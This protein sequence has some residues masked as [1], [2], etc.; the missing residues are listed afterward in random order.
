MRLILIRHGRPEWRL[1]R[2]ASLSQYR[3]GTLAYDAAGLSE[4]GIRKIRALESRLPEAVVWSSDLPRAKETAEIIAR[5]K[6]VDKVSPV[7]RELQAPT[8]GARFPGRLR[9]P[10][11]VW[12]LIHWGCWVAGIGEC[13][14]WPRAAWRRAGEAARLIRGSSVGEKTVILVSHGW[15]ITLLSAYLRKHGL[16]VHGPLF[17]ASYAFGGMTDY[18]LRLSLKMSP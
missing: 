2:L 5:G 3:Q 17:P 7:F 8:I 15:F 12:S 16:I 1:P 9:F 13:P 10:P 11:T 4:D 6:A 14:E 18:E